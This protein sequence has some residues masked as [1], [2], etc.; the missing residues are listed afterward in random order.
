MTH[1]VDELALDVVGVGVHEWYGDFHEIAREEVAA[2]FVVD[3][4]V[5]NPRVPVFEVPNANVALSTLAAVLEDRPADRVPVIGVTGT[6]GKT[7]TTTLVESAMT[8]LGRRV[9]RLGTLGASVAGEPH[10]LG[11]T[12]PSPPELHALLSTMV[13]QGCDLAI[14]EAGSFGLRSHRVDAIGFHLGVFTNLTRDHL[15][16]HGTMEAYAAAKAR[17]FGELLRPPGGWPRALLCA[18]DPWWPAMHPPADRWTYGFAPAADLRLS[19]ARHAIEGSTATLETPVGTARLRCRLPG[20]YNL[21]NATA[22]VGIMLSLEVPLEEACDAVARA[23]GP[24]GRMEVVPNDRE[25]SVVVDYAH[26]PNGLRTVLRALR[27]LTR[28]RLWVVFGCGGDRDP[29][30]RPEMGGIASALADEVVLTSDNP[31]GESALAI[32][33]A[34]VAGMIR[35]PTHVELDRAAAIAWA[36][37]H[38]SPG[39]TV[40]VAG[41]GHE[42]TQQ[43]GPR[44]HPFD[45]RDAIAHA[46]GTTPR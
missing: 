36:L 42:T 10:P 29:G 2:A 6:D 40:L 20:P 33:Q 1:L 11:R 45:D 13:Q 22:A 43:I 18:D 3:R 14:M 17:L 9:G 38:A 5:T 46:L 12:V 28:R 25:L 30:K 35:S 21:L 44:T 41:K 24:S 16:V 4:P 19:D 15:D 27:P 39:D 7:T 26:T 37:E 31:R 34:I 23:T 8:M 32:N